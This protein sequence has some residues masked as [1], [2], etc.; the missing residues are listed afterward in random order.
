MTDQYIPSISAAASRILEALAFDDVLLVPGYSEI[1]PSAVDTT[2]KLTRTIALNIP[3][4][5]SAGRL[6]AMILIASFLSR[7]PAL[8]FRM[9]E[10]TSISITWTKRK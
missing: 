6:H 7:L 9:R 2:T 3:L 8:N 4:I 5:S 10:S 1:I